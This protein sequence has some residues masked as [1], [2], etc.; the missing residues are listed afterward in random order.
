MGE[1]TRFAKKIEDYKVAS[2]FSGAGGIDLG[3]E[4][5]SFNVMWANEIDKK[6][7]ETF[8]LNHK[9]TTLIEGDINDIEI[10]DIPDFDIMIAGFPCQAFSIAGLRKGFDD[11]RGNLFFSLEKIFRA[12]K[13]EIIFLEN[14]RN[15]VTHDKGNTF[16]VITETLESAGYHCKYRTMNAC[17]YGNI[18][19]NRDRI[20]IL[21]FL[22]EEKY[23]R[24]RFPDPIPL[25]KK[26]EDI[27]DLESHVDRKFYYTAES[28]GQERYD[29]LVETAKE[30]PGAVYQWRRVIARSNKTG[31]CPT[32]TANMGTG[33]HNVPLVETKYGFRK[34][35]PREC[36]GMMGFPEDFKLPDQSDFSLYKQAGNSVVV[37]VIYRIAE[38]LKA[39]LN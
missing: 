8:R 5:A 34:L 15:L 38:H 16:R 29:K 9:N 28:F 14:V 4:M 20:Y 2:F 18:P 35:T 23:S 21:A 13:P 30:T 12:K 37:P 31:L 3:F 17:E 27:I 32:L 1:E 36:F 39:V 26:P 24:F 6:A 10:E 33:G 11:K 19:Q 7:C 22:N 25:T